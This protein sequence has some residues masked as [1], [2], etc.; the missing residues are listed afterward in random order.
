VERADVALGARP[1]ARRCAALYAELAHRDPGFR[2]EFHRNEI[3][4]RTNLE[5]VG[6][7]I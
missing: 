4:M 1:L 6:Q 7:T 5:F 3:R 2:E